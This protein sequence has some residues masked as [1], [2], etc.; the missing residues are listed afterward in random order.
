MLAIVMVGIVSGSAAA[1][2]F[3]FKNIPG[4]KV[5]AGVRFLRP[6]FTG[7]DNLTIFSGIYEVTLSLPINERWSIDGSLPYSRYSAEDGDYSEGFIGN[8]YAGMQYL[9][10]SGNSSKIIS[11][12]AYIPAADDDPANIFLGTAINQ[13][14]FIKYWPDFWTLTGNFSYFNIETGGARLGLE[15]GP[16]LIIP[17]GE[18]DDE[19]EFL[20]HYGL[21]AGYQGERF[22]AFTELIGLGILTGTGSGFSERFKHSINFGV[23]YVSPHFLPGVFYKI[24]LSETELDILDGVIGVNLEFVM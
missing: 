17:T 14:D 21:T 22:A 2:T 5:Q 24:S 7:A 20:V 11:F 9:M 6:N 3:M 10:K 1:Q 18:Y 12:G 16:D 8:I 19:L 15:I 13:E 23:S 4:E